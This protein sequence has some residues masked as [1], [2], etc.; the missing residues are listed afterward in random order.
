M[1]TFGGK[2]AQVLFDNAT[3]I[4]VVV[5]SGLGSVTSAQLLVV[6]D[7]T[8]SLTQQV[9][10]AAF[11][12]GIFGGG[13]LNQ[14][15]EPNGP[16]HPAKPGSILQIYATGLSGTGTISALVNGNLLNQRSVDRRQA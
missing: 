2:P 9:P 11:N 8:S 10:L 14:N 13:I 6:V 4:N 3:Q 5:P 12:P 7:G 1:V 15:G 16:S